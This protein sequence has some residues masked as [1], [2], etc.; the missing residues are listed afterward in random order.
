MKEKMPLIRT[1]RDLVQKSPEAG[2]AQDGMGN[3]PGNQ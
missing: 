3:L 2:Q 1:K